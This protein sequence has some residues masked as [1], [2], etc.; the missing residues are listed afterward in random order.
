MKQKLF[1]WEEHTVTNF[2]IDFDLTKSI[3]GI[4]KLMVTQ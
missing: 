3:L 2:D 4:F 1:N